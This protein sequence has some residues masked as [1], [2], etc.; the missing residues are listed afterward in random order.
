MLFVFSKIYVI[1]LTIHNDS[2]ED[3]HMKCP[4]CSAEVV[5]SKFCHECG[6]PLAAK[7]IVARAANKPEQTKVQPEPAPV[8]AP[9]TE[10]I[11][12]T[13]QTNTVTVEKNRK[14]LLI[15]AVAVILILI[16]SV[17]GVASYAG[18]KA[19]V[20]IAEAFE[21]TLFNAQSFDFSIENDSLTLLGVDGFV[22]YGD[23]LSGSDIYFFLGDEDHADKGFHFVADKGN[24][25]A[26]TYGFFAKTS[27]Q[28]VLNDITELADM[29]GLE[30]TSDLAAL[31]NS[32]S[33]SID[34]LVV[35]GNI[36]EE[37]I[38]IFYNN[39]VV[40]HLAGL[41]GVS[42]SEV[43]DYDTG[44]A[45]FY[46]FLEKGLT[47]DA[48]K[49]NVTIGKLGEKSFK[50]TVDIEEAATCLYNYIK[51]KPELAFIANSTLFGEI[52]PDEF[53][54]LGELKIVVGIKDGYISTVDFM[55]FEVKFSGYNEA[56]DIASKHEYVKTLD[57]GDAW[58]GAI[59]NGIK[60]GADIAGSVF[61]AVFGG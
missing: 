59:E 9:K 32:G 60:I 54:D 10:P 37:A 19:Q 23:G 26:G 21:N 38:K 58:I 39:D 3:L 11:R 1:I 2:K 49:A 17:A 12:S 34:A 36:N 22:N 33:E 28:G 47:D 48:I 7:K 42:K 40:P 31:I 30:I 6:A 57:S 13:A 14:P 29:M 16:I 15:A 46:D 53:R 20:E 5:D 44:K 43:P 56:K 51:A 24:V 41:Y 45:I 61:D 52:N 35:N 55:N 27:V 50:I 18:K 8:Q 25:I 4:K